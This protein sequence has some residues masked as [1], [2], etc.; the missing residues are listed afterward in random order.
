[1]YRGPPKLVTASNSGRKA[2]AVGETKNMTIRFRCE[3]CSK[4]VKAPDNLAGKMGKCPGCGVTVHIPPSEAAGQLDNAAPAPTERPTATAG[5]RTAVAVTTRVCE[6]CAQS[7]PQEAIKCPHCHEWRRDIQHSA[8]RIGTWLGVAIL[9]VVCGFLLSILAKN[10]HDWERNTG[11]WGWLKTGAFGGPFSWEAFFSSTTGK[12]M[13]LD[14][15][16]FLIACL[17][18]YYYAIEQGRMTG[19]H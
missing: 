6:C 3:K 18:T 5:Q 9:T 16:I 8:Q 15:I 19:K 17:L 4:I 11:D 2:E 13:V 14:A 12:L 10:R 7:I 1:M